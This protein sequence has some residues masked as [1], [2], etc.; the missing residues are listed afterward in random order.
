[1][2]MKTIP[3]MTLIFLMLSFSVVAWSEDTYFKS[4]T[5]DDV[6]PYDNGLTAFND[7]GIGTYRS[8][9]STRDGFYWTGSTWGDRNIIFGS[10]EYIKGDSLF[11]NGTE[12]FIF[13]RRDFPNGALTQAYSYDGS[14]LSGETNIINGLPVNP[15]YY[16]GYESVI[17][18]GTT[19]LF[20]TASNGAPVGYSWNSTGWNI[21]SS[22][23]TNINTIAPNSYNYP[24]YSSLIY[25]NETYLIIQF[26]NGNFYGAKWN[27]TEWETNSFIIENLDDIDTDTSTS[28]NQ[29]NIETF[30]YDGDNYFVIGN[31]TGDFTFAKLTTTPSYVNASIKLNDSVSGALNNFSVDIDGYGLYSTTNG[32]I[33]TNI[34]INTT[35][36]LDLIFYDVSES[37]YGYYNNLTVNNHGF[38]IDNEEYTGTIILNYNE[39]ILKVNDS[40]LNYT[41]NMNNVNYSTTD[42][43]IETGINITEL[44]SYNLTYFGFNNGYLYHDEQTREVNFTDSFNEYILNWASYYHN[45]IFYAY[46]TN[47]SETI[48]TFSIILDDTTSY[49]TTDGS[50]NTGIVHDQELY[51]DIY[52][53]GMGLYNSTHEYDTREYSNI[54]FGVST[55][56]HTGNI[57]V[58]SLPPLY[59]GVGSI[60]W[61][62]QVHYDTGSYTSSLYNNYLL[63]DNATSGKYCSLII[64]TGHSQPL[65][66]NMTFTK[67][68]TQINLEFPFDFT[69]LVAHYKMDDSSSPLIDSSGN[70]GE[71]LVYQATFEHEGIFN[72]SMKFD[73]VN[74]FIQVTAINISDHHTLTGFAKLTNLS[75]PHETLFG[76]GYGD[77]YFLTISNSAQSL[78]Y[79]SGAITVSV[80][81][82]PNMNWQNYGVMRNGTDVKFF[83]N[84]T[85]IGT[86]QT[87]TTADPDMFFGA[88]GR[89]GNQAPSNP[90]QGYV[91]EVLVF[92][93]SLS[94]NKMLNLH[95]LA[96]VY[97]EYETVNRS[98]NLTIRTCDDANCIGETFVNIN[99]VSPSD[100]SSLDYYPY[101]QWCTD[102]TTTN[103]DYSPTLKDVKIFYHNLSYD[104]TNNNPSAPTDL[105]FSPSPLYNNHTLIANASG[106]TDADSDTI[107]YYYR[108]DNNTNIIQAYSINNT[109]NVSL[110]ENQTI[111]VYTKSYDG[112]NYSIS[113]SENIKVI[114]YV[115]P[116]EWIPP[117]Y[118]IN[119]T[120]IVNFGY[121]PETDNGLKNL[122]YIIALCFVVGI[123]GV[124][125][126]NVFFVLISGF[127]LV[128][129]SLIIMMCGT[130]LGFIIILMAIGFIITGLHMKPL[131]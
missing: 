27:G 9:A 92:N 84:G 123:F 118:A 127:S 121:C 129:L 87:L 8:G 48:N 58:S 68:V 102:M 130:V 107:T 46:D 17:L 53:Y 22:V 19:H 1:M 64:D 78:Y 33:K 82:A 89:K 77:F 25:D 76:G 79:R 34:T 96:N 7:T 103:A 74:D 6:T 41:V 116:Y 30:V 81:Y 94:N 10:Y 104:P 52:Y 20:R 57:E 114:E 125:M 66:D 4:S 49:S 83:V 23:V 2:K 119:G 43:V 108:F 56:S 112:Q 69:N 101:V 15:A 26:N 91:D 124:T 51:Y 13:G 105:I 45:L 35:K 90:L 109:F 31:S 36:V 18:D 54:I 95:N 37:E 115:A 3:I 28:S 55:Y 32:T 50:I 85:Q 88:I 71:A 44:K 93:E 60:N 98:L 113:Y 63:L 14:S 106:S 86:T 42:G 75:L 39:I 97:T 59:S 11:M 38:T 100:L 122:W 47:N 117:T 29:K 128:F 16:T 126:K 131:D 21:N 120:E 70:N 12:Y 40:T 67:N 111:T 110:F 5:L 99:D 80:P 72:Y 73:G 65:Y 61:T 24:D 62:N